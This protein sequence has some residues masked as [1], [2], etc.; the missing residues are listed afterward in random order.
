VGDGWGFLR[1][2]I[3]FADASLIMLLLPFGQ[4][5]I[6]RRCA[7]PRGSQK[8]PPVPHQRRSQAEAARASA[9]REL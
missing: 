8:A 4:L 3:R 2:Q 9:E 1:S 5:R 6:S 7:A